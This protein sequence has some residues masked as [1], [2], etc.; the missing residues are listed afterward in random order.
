MFSL[1]SLPLLKANILYKIVKPLV[2]VCKV[3]SQRAKKCITLFPR[4][5]L[6]AEAISQLI[7]FALI[8][9]VGQTSPSFQ[10]NTFGF[11]HTYAFEK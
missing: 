4:H 8:L 5:S 2:F 1:T 3:M 6:V 11:S 9:G 10:M 7:S